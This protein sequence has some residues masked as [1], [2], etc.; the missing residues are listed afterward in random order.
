MMET[1]A[2]DTIDRPRDGLLPG[3]RGAGGVPAC[4]CAGR[5]VC[6]RSA[7]ELERLANHTGDLGALAGDVG[8][9]P[10]ASY[11]GRLRGDFLNLTAA[12]VREPLRPRAGPPGRGRASTSTSDGRRTCLE[13]LDAALRDVDRAVEPA[14]GRPPRSRP[15]SRTP[16][17]CRPR[18]GAVSWAWW[19]W[20]PGPAGCE[21]D[22][23]T[24]LPSGIYRFAHIP[25]STWATGDVFARAYVR[26]LEIQRS[27]GVRPHQ[28]AALPAGP[29]RATVGRS[30]ARPL[31]RVALV[32]GWRGE[33]CHVALTDG[34]G[35]LSRATRS[36][37]RRSTTGPAWPW[38][39]AA[40]RSPTSRCATRASTCRTAGTT[41]NSMGP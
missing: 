26:W 36:W 35:P 13:R 32:E 15:G 9:L 22:V 27:V 11:C 10:T 31:W 33:I 20:R 30:A 34:Q 37:I 6:G 3:G 25:V 7:L 39:C 8:F 29:V 18:R 19:A 17:S 23:R 5:G 14:V 40:S 16:A 4:R 41:S 12:A 1:L 38:P 28:L 2:G 24:T 21:R